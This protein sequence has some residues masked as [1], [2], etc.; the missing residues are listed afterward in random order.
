[1]NTQ[2][3]SSDPSNYLRDLVTVL[4]P[5]HIKRPRDDVKSPSGPADVT[6]SALNELVKELVTALAMDAG[7]V[8][9][10]SESYL[11]PLGSLQQLLAVPEAA[12]RVCATLN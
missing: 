2:V 8:Y 12:T 6:V 7:K 3:G 10:I 5:M 9:L 1:M 11:E 4:E